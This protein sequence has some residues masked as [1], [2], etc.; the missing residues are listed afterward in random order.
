VPDLQAASFLCGCDR[1]KLDAVHEYL[2][3]EFPH[4]GLKDLH[5]P[6]RLVQA[7]VPTLHGEHHVVS[8]E[9]A[10]ILTYYAVL[11]HEFLQH[12][13]EVVRQRLTEW[14]VAQMIRTSRTAVV[15]K[16]GAAAL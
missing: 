14:D 2:N 11:L 1:P 5:A 13:V 7:G 10:N 3:E 15:S 9:C 6:T 16:D 8:I 4:W 12:P